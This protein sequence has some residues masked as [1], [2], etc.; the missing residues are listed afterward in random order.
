GMPTRGACTA[1]ELDPN[2][3][4]GKRTLYATMYG[5]GVYKS[6]DG[7]KTWRAINAG[8]RTDRNNHFTDL[9]LHADGGL[10]ALCGPSKGKD[11]LPVAVGGLFRSA[12]GGETWTDLIAGLKL[13]HPYSFAVDP[14]DSRII[15]LAASAV[16][17]NHGQEGLYKSIDGGATW[18]KIKIDWPGGPYSYV[19]PRFLTVDPYR[20]ERVWMSVGAC[21]LMVSTDRG[22]TFE[23]VKGLPFR[24][25]NRVTVDPR[26]HETIWVSTFGGG[27]WRGPAKE[28][29]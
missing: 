14:V 7:A 8:L 22:E 3:S 6:T 15:Y 20:P 27:I 21:G 5:G 29:D 10:F 11:N 19:H 23:Q 25:A 26:D 1:V 18:R 28:K 17:R 24:G 2:S 9:K 16:P 12:D 13:F 4:R